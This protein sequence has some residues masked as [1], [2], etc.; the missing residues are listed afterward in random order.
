MRSIPSPAPEQVTARSPRAEGG[1]A[2]VDFALVSGLLSLLFVAVLQVG[3]A[4]YVRN[5]L[6]FCAAEGA[7]AGARSG[8]TPGDAV[9]RTERLIATSVSAAYAQGVTADVETVD[10]VRV[11][12]VHVTA[13]LPVI[14]FF[15]PARGV[16]VTGRAFEEDQ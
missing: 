12:A 4:L 9:A 3:L 11:V 7:R 2:I 13:P 1:A 16:N 15:G 10:G 5:T 6:T 8:A 14:A